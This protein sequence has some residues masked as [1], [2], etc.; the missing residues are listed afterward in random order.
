MRLIFATLGPE[1]AWAE[2]DSIRLPVRNNLAADLQ[3][4]PL[5]L[6]PTSRV[7]WGEEEVPDV[8]REEGCR[9][10]R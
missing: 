8:V 3:R 1:L 4:R 6:P 10:S 9:G 7:R 5:A 2:P